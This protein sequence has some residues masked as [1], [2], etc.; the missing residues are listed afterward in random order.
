MGFFSKLG[1]F[2]N[3]FDGNV[4][5]APPGLPGGG[6][7]DKTFSPLNKVG[8]AAAKSINNTVGK[9]PGVPDLP[10][11][12]EGKGKVSLADASGVQKNSSAR[13]PIQN[14]SSA[15]G[16]ISPAAVNPNQALID[17]LGGAGFAGMDRQAQIA[18]ENQARQALGGNVGKMSNADMLAQLKIAGAGPAEATPAPAQPQPAIAQRSFQDDLFGGLF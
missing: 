15:R 9:I 8:N 11:G 10:K 13:G 5:E 6:F 14:Y 1:G 16:Q 3:P 18:L 17:Q 7:I 4:L 12:M 2:L